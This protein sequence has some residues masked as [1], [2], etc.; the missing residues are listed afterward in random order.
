[1]NLAH[2]DD[3]YETPDWLFEDIK[4]KTGVEFK[5][6]ACASMANSKCEIY[7]SEEE[8]FLKDGRE[9]TCYSIWC[10]PP[11]S[12]NGKFVKKLIKLWNDYGNDIV[13]LLTWNDFG[14]KYCDELR[15]LIGTDEIKI[16][17]YGK[18]IFDKNGIPSEWPSRLNYCAVWLKKRDK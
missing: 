15:P 2:K 12:K 11:R 16:Y 9:T 10:N 4:T 17:N 1:M 8:D 3:Y 14:N 6:D 18:I 5:M 7:C 13:I